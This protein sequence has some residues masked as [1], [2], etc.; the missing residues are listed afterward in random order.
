MNK[1]VIIGSNHAGIAAANTLLDQY[2]EQEVIMIEKNSNLSYLGCGTALWVGRQIDSYEGLF[3]TKKEDFE[4]KGAKIHTETTVESVDFHQKQVI[5]KTST[6]ATFCEKYDTLI[7]A[8]GSK[9]ISPRIPGT[10][11]K[12]IHFLKRFQDGQAVDQLMTDPTVRTVAVIGAGYIGVEIAEA[13]KRRGKNVL[14]FDGAERSLPSYYD[15]EFTD[16]MD[17]TLADNEI[18]LHFGELAE[19]YKGT[20]KVEAIV[21]NKGTYKVDLV[22]NAIG[23]LPNN[24]LGKEHLEL[25]QNGAYIVDEHQQ[26]SDPSVYAVGDCATIY[27]NALG[28]ISYIALATNAVRTGLVAGHN[29]GGTKLASSGVQGSNGISIFGLNMVSTGLSVEAARK[30]TIDVLYTDYTDLQKPAFMSDNHPVKI[31]IVYERNSRRIVGAQMCSQAEISMGIHLFSL[32]IEQKVTIDELKLL[33]I[34]FLPH[35]NQ[36]YNYITMAAL[37]AE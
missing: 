6:G 18:E 2:Q 26:T 11:L 8:T 25:F 1:T 22:I 13:V 35:F 14:L 21:T 36:P 37:T 20:E 27:S 15:R 23:F 17:K 7:L 29:I 12:N 10:N 28:K 19:E 31:R 33:D 16:E 9:P 32:A 4:A 34:F 5:C 24:E 3:Y 30:H